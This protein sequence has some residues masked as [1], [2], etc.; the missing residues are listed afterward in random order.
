MRVLLL[1][2]SY[3]PDQCGVGD[4]IEKLANSLGKVKDVRVGVLTTFVPRH[5]RASTSAVDLLDVVH[6]W[7]FSEL[8]RLISTIRRWKPDVVHIQYPSQGFSRPGLSSFMPLICRVMGLR[9]LQTWHEPHGINQA[10]R[11]KSIIYFFALR[12]GAE[13][14]IFVR[15]NYI[16]LIPRC[17]NNLIKRIPD[18]IISNA[19]S[20]PPSS[21]NEAERID[22]RCKYLGSH[23]RLVIFFGFVYPSKGIELLFDIA[24]PTSDSIVVVGSIK[25]VA[26]MRELDNFA[27]A[28]QWCDGQLHITGFL[29]PKEAADLLAVADA[30]VLP[31]RDGGGDWNTSI[32]SALAQGT[33]VITTAVPPRGDEP[34]RNLYTATP[35]DVDEMR[36][37]LDRI[38]GRRIAPISVENQWKEIATSHVAFY[39]KIINQF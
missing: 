39:Q 34:K 36:G 1:A 13:G 20:L 7:S 32:H 37:A 19:S 24:N 27:R 5:Q 11:M 4:Y 2:G 21:L 12:L 3:P 17:F 14:L 9:V 28:K 38:A 33:L 8:P 16:S 6:Q 15:S 29:A 10:H 26:Y 30:V 18:V 31:F 35:L 23:R 25:D 22:L